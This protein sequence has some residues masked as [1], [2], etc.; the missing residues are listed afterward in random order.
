[1]IHDMEFQSSLSN[2]VECILFIYQ[3]PIL[4]NIQHTEAE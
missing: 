2:Y 1:M 4:Q 3:L